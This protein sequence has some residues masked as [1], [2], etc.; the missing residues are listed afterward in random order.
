MRDYIIC[1]GFVATI[2]CMDINT[3]LPCEIVNA[4]VLMI[5]PIILSVIMRNYEENHNDY[6]GL[7]IFSI[8]L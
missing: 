6:T 5:D 3:F 8:I 7:N 4:I 2:Y 1:S